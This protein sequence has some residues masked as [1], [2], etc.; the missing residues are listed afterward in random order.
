[1]LPE[2]LILGFLIVLGACV[3]SFL[4]V[5]VY[6]MPLGLSLV[7][8]PSRCPK[9]EKR[10]AWHD[11]VPVLGWIM[12]G[13]KCRNCKLPISPRYPIIEAITGLM[14][15]LAYL[16]FMQWGYGPCYTFEGPNEFG[17][18][19]KQHA[20][21]TLQRDAIL[22]AVYLYLLSSLLAAS[23]IDAEHFV[24]PL[25][26]CWLMAIVGVIGHALGDTSDSPGNVVVGPVGSAI[27]LGG[28]VGLVISNLLLWRGKLTRSFADAMPLLEHE[29]EALLKQAAPDV[30]AELPPDFTPKQIRAEMRL[31]MVYLM[32]PL[33][34]AGA[35]VTLITLVPAIGNLW[36]SLIEPVMVRAALGALLGGLIGGF[37]VWIT[38][39]LGSIAFGR[40]AMGLGDVHLMFGVGAI[41]GAL[42]VTV[43]FFIAPFFGLALALWMLVSRKRRE[44]P[45]GPYLALG[46]V[47]A[48]VLH[49]A[50][51]NYPGFE[52]LGL[53]I[54]SLFESDS[55]L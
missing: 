34:L 33:V 24:I 29:K 26:I 9:C 23:L 14:F 46:S 43:A 50:I 12:L 47:A 32:P 41:I 1:M 17:V 18:W 48:L 51:D 35:L 5:V 19:V 52:G 31:E 4:N 38:R 42:H 7:H 10:L 54:R 40:E 27:A 49:C 11:N 25:W 55:V 53:F 44:L 21:M 20:H 28:G 30:P 16:A 45:Y 36:A 22:F 15:G 2:W 13:G 6:R 8:P 37:V 39:I 3:G